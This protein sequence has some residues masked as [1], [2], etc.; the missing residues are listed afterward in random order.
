MQY[1][2]DSKYSRL[3]QKQSFKENV[4]SSPTGLRDRTAAEPCRVS[5]GEDA[6]GL[7]TE[8]CFLE[9]AQGQKQNKRVYTDWCCLA[10]LAKLQK[11]PE[12]S[13]V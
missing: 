6:E 13:H 1:F 3:L 5:R 11:G 8:V 10:T 9:H 12:I 7:P 2:L 4:K